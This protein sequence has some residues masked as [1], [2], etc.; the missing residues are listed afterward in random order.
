MASS[1]LELIE[2]VSE[3]F[4][5]RPWHGH[6]L[7]HSCRTAIPRQ[8]RRPSRHQSSMAGQGP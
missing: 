7:S 3:R 8:L 2:Q 5:N 4:T 6:A 1:I